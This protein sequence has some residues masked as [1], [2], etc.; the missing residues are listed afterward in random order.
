MSVN[1][2]LM[3][4]AALVV[5]LLILALIGDRVIDRL[6]PE[7]DEEAA[8]ARLEVENLLKR[9]N[10]EAAHRPRLRAKTRPF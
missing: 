3:L 8:E 5:F 4:L 10:A 9:A 2:L 7:T 6:F 1:S